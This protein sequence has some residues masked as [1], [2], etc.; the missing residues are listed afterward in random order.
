MPTL[1]S[2]TKLDSE[3]ILLKK[4]K[5]QTNSYANRPI[6]KSWK[7]RNETNKHK[8]NTEIRKK[9]SLRQNDRMN[10]FFFL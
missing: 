4:R 7:D 3:D 5:H 6:W 9:V 1:Y 2:S 8:S 10:L